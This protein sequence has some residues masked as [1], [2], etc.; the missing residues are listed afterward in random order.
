MSLCDKMTYDEC[1][2]ECVE[3]KTSEF[4]GVCEN[5]SD[6][7]EFNVT[8]QQ[9]CLA[10]TVCVLPNGSYALNMTETECNSYG[11][12]STNCPDTCEVFFSA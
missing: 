6:C 9:E 11:Q 1:Y 7:I 12:C 3:N 5:G 10:T 8:S 2:V 4:C